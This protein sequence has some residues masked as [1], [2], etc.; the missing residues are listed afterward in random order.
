MKKLLLSSVALLGLS[1]AASAADLPR[2]AAPPVYAPVPVFT[3]TGF[4]V[5][6]NAGY[7]WGDN[8]NDGT[9]FVPAGALAPGVPV[10]GTTVNTFGL[11]VGNGGD[12]GGFTA[13]GTAGYN[14]QA[15]GFV[16]GV[17]GDIN[18]ADI[19]GGNNNGF[20]FGNT[21]TFVP[22]GGAAG[23]YTFV[24]SGR[25][26]FDWFGTLRARVG[27]A[28]D[29]TLVYATGG[30]AFASGGDSNNNGLGF[31]LGCAGFAFGCGFNNDDDWRSGWTI[32]GGVEYAFT[33]NLT[34]KIEGLWVSLD[35]G[36]GN[37]VVAIPVAGN[38]NPPVRLN[39]NNN[40]D[41]E[42]FVARLGIN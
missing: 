8:N 4:Y 15:G 20:G 3:W 11:G 33:N 42:F 40:S 25:G 28:F 16:F 10:A 24:G 6:V 12:D 2:R 39:G 22:P 38:P 34:A 27:V 19:N 23:T 1:V 30:F 14:W 29:R 17:E 9:V 36:N 35:G 5:G 21:V 26:G 32:G 18:W 37:G 31:G 13:G 7:A 41:N